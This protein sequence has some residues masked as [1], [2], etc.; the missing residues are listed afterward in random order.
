[1]REVILQKSTWV[2]SYGC[3]WKNQLATTLMFIVSSLSFTRDQEFVNLLGNVNGKKAMKLVEAKFKSQL[4]IWEELLITQI[5]ISGLLYL[6]I[7]KQTI[8]KK[9]KKSLI[10]GIKNGG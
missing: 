8:L 4:I 6:R 3:F 9:R 1:L 2:E 5:V 10:L 7:R